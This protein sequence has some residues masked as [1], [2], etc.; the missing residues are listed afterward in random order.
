MLLITRKLCL[1]GKGLLPGLTVRATC[2]PAA[3]AASASA[4]LSVANMIKDG[5]STPRVRAIS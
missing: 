1:E 5:L 3:A 2:Q 4:M